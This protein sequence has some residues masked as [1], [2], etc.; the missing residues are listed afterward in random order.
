MATPVVPNQFAVGKNR[1]I[2]KPT[3]ATFNFETG[4]TTFKSIDWGRADE[5]RSS[6]LDY[7]K[8]DIMRVA[9]QLLS[10]LPR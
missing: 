10:K 8:D 9:Q 4:Q 1:I 5:Q 7:R 6:G 2:H 3:T